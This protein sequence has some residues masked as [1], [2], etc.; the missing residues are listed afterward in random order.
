MQR[1]RSFYDRQPLLNF[2]NKNV[3]VVCR[4]RDQFY[5]KL[6][7]VGQYEILLESD[8]KLIVIF[9]H[10]IEYIAEIF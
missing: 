7:L 4:S 1:S 6:R 3:L 5:G 10:A 8:G 2:V 9:K